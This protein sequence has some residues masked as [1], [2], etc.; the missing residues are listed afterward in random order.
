MQLAL[1]L[2]IGGTEKLVYEIVQRVNREQV[3]PVVCCLDEIGVFGQKLREA[4]VPVYVLHRAPGLDWSLLSK[5]REIIVKEQIDVIHAHQYTPYFY[6]L[7]ASLYAK[8]T[9]AP[10]RPEIIFTEH[11]RFY[12]DVRKFKRVVSNPI[13]SLFTKEIV[14]ISAS[15]KQ[16]LID[17]ENFPA[18]RI[19]VIYNGIDLE[20]FSKTADRLAKRRELGLNADDKVF[21]IVARLDPI[22]NHAMLLRAC[23]QLVKTVPN[24]YLLIVGDGPERAKLKEL[25]A[26]LGIVAHVRFLGARQDISELLQT[27]DVFALS[28]FSEGTSVTLLEAMGVGVPIVATNVGGNPEVISD[29]ETGFLV[30]S[31]NADDMANKLLQLLQNDTLRQRMGNAGKERVHALFSIEKMVRAYVDLY[32]SAAGITS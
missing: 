2:V 29:G 31:D 21:G 24:A 19:R 7:M 20:R 16:S 17:Y 1:S 6:G 12:P 32:L 30:E 10:F 13:L 28:S 27:F 11:G 23:Q 15:T 14:T 25:T 4:G 26:S 3:S 18:R 22:K 9:L 5:L 8:I